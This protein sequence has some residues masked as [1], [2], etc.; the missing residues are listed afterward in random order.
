MEVKQGWNASSKTGVNS[1][2]CWIDVK[3]DLV[4]WLTEKDRAHLIQTCTREFMSVNPKVSP[5]L[6][7]PPLWREQKVHFDSDLPGAVAVTL[8]SCVTPELWSTSSLK[9]LGL[10]IFL[11]QLKH[12]HYLCLPG[13]KFLL[14]LRTLGLGIKSR[15]KEIAKSWQKLLQLSED[16]LGNGCWLYGGQ[17]LLCSTEMGPAAE[18]HRRTAQAASAKLIRCHT[19]MKLAEEV[20]G[21]KVNF[22]QTD[23]QSFI[24]CAF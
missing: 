14:S 23:N 11:W 10:V 18:R 12:N 3:M 16:W 7:S 6:D 15:W 19:P 8:K 24:C 22:F 5:S 1:R 13:D 20:V 9:A 21:M 4:P 17:T 2:S